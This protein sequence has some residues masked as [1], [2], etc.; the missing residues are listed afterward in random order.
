MN[1]LKRYYKPTDLLIISHLRQ[2]ARTTLTNMSRQTRIPVSTIFDKIKFFKET[3][4][5]KKNTSIVSF[6]RFGYNT[7][8]MIFL[9]ASKEERP[10]L[11]EILKTSSN[12]NSLFKVG[13]GWD[14][15]VEVIFPNFKEI[16]E[17]LE[18]IEENVSLKD[19]EVFYIIEELKR[20]DF[21]SNPKKLDIHNPKQG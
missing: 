12:V 15:I 11:I 1:E 10:K 14:L 21:F 16:E 3:G 18:N 8:A 2:D 20:E 5:I 4:L 17:F 13:N 19:K 7:K 6:E 9:S